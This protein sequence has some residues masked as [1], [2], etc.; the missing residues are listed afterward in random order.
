MA[1]VLPQHSSISPMHLSTQTSH[2]Y[3]DH[4]SHSRSSTS[5]RASH[6]RH[7]MS[8]Y[9]HSRSRQTSTVFPPFHSS[10]SYALVRDFA[11]SPHE[12]LHYGPIDE[13]ESGHSSP[14]ADYDGGRRLSDP[15]RSV[16]GNI[17]PW[18]D[19]SYDQHPG[20]RQQ[21]P[22]TSFAHDDS[23]EESG[24]F[25]R[26][27]STHRKSKSYTSMDDFAR[28]RRRSSRDRYNKA[29]PRSQAGLNSQGLFQGGAVESEG[30]GQSAHESASGIRTDS[31]VPSSLPYRVQ[32]AARGP[33]YDIAL[34]EAQSQHPPFRED[35]ETVPYSPSAEEHRP[36]SAS[37]D[38]SFAGPSLALYDFA[39]ENDNELALRE[40]Q[41]I[42]V[43]YRHGQG[44]LVAMNMENGEQ[45]LVPEEYVRLLRDIEG[46]GEEDTDELRGVES[47]ASP[48]EDEHHRNTSMR[49]MSE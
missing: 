29:G 49:E 17:G 2:G 40:G 22:N 25:S 37:L 12:S 39:P 19:S 30:R 34:N 45:G 48:D 26:R 41:I 11:Y 9:S 7:R 3:D 16:D 31:P 35:S 23:D 4:A 46:W 20:S 5:P 38:E 8:G 47:S 36:E 32:D 24:G 43:G 10:L 14:G 33:G 27:I 13:Y 6:P 21:L 18:G 28:G 15:H 42:Q 1:A 44:W